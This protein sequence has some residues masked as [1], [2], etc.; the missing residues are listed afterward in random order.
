MTTPTIGLDGILIL[1]NNHHMRRGKFIVIDGMDGSGKSTEMRLMK[2]ELAGTSAVFTHEPGGTRRGEEIRKMLL[3]RSGK[4]SSVSD[5]FLFWAARAMHVGE[6]IAPALR[7]GE[8]VISDRFD[9]STFAYQIIADK[10]PRLT[11][12]F[13]KCR[14]AVLGECMPDAYIFLDLPISISKARISGDSSK[15]SRYDMKPAAYHKAVRRG[16][17]EFG[18]ATHSKVFIVDGSRSPDE[19]HKDVWQIVRKILL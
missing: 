11:E 15:R 4:Q 2:K 9:A 13:H 14:R 1:V 5:F 16:F 3:A 8:N 7:A 10:N 12:L 6:V 18:P 19:V 17:K